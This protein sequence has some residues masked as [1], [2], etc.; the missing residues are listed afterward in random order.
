[1]TTATTDLF[2]ANSH[3]FNS[4]RA[5]YPDEDLATVCVQTPRAF[6]AV[7]AVEGLECALRLS[8]HCSDRRA[9][10]AAHAV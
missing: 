10:G 5:L 6:S 2:G 7:M 1:M 4:E 9:V 3:L 8:A